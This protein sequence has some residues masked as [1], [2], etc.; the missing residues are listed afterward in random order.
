M[1]IHQ[2]DKNDEEIFFNIEVVEILLN[3]QTKQRKKEIN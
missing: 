2:L 1:S 3:G